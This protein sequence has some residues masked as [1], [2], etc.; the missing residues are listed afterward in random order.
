MKIKP[1]IYTACDTKYFYDHALAFCKSAANNKQ[2]VHIAISPPLHGFPIPEHIDYI[3]N[4]L[5]LFTEEQRKYVVP[6]KILD[7][8]YECNIKEERAYYAALRFL[9]LPFVLAHFGQVLVTDIDCFFNQEILFDAETDVGVYLRDGKNLGANEY[10]KQGM[11][12]AAGAFYVTDMSREFVSEIKRNLLREPLIWFSDQKAI[13]D[14]FQ[15]Y[16]SNMNILD[17]SKDP[18]FLDWEFKDTSAI[19]TGKGARKHENKNYLARKK[20]FESQ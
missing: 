2:L 11:N 1:L 6:P 14:A 4:F 12:I 3:R 17:F 7:Y 9:E 15:L 18:N 8:F 13:Y 10:E 5:S 16:S 20:E 19:W